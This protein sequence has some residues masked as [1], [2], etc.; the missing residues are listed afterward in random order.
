MVRLCAAITI[1]VMGLMTAGVSPRAYA[2]GGVC[3]TGSSFE[4]GDGNMT[5]SGSCSEDWSNAPNITTSAT[6]YP[7]GST[8]N[9]FTGGAKEDDLNPAVGL[10]SVPPNKN[11]LIHFYTSNETVNG[12][13]YL[14][15]AFTRAATSGNADL[16]VE[17]NHASSAVTP[18]GTCQASGATASNGLCTPLQRTDGDALL[19]F[20]FPGGGGPITS[21]QVWRWATSTSSPNFKIVK[22]VTTAA[23][24]LVST[25][26]PPCWSNPTTPS[27]SQFNGDSNAAAIPNPLDPTCSGNCLGIATFGEAGVNLSGTGIFSG[28]GCSH[29]GDAWAKSRSSDSG[30]SALQDY[31]APVQTFISNCGTIN[32]VKQTSPRGVNQP[33]SFNTNVPSTAT[34]SIAPNASGNFN[35]ND[36]G[37]STSNSAA[38]TE[39]ITDI[40]PGQTYTVQEN[41]PEPSGFVYNGFSCTGSGTANPASSTTAQ[42][43]SITVNASNVETCTFTNKQVL[44]PGISTTLQ[45]GSTVS[46]GTQVNDTATLTGATSTAGGTVTYSYY[47]DSACT[48]NQQTAGTVTVNNGSVPPSNKVTFNSAG[49][50]YFQASYSGDAHNGAATSPCTSEQLVVQ[51]N[52]PSIGTTLNATSISVGS[53]D[54]DTSTLTGAT[55]NAGGTVTYTVY[56]DSGCSQNPVAG[57]TVTV[58]SGKVPNSNTLT[59]NTAGTYYWQASYSG[60]ANNNSA[61]SPCTSEIV[62]VNPLSPTISTSLN[63]TSISVGGTDYDTATLTGATSNAGGT[64]TYTV[65]SDTGCS[66]NPVDGGTVTVAGGKVPNSNTLSFNTAGTYYWQASYSGDGNNSSAVSPCTS[67]VVT[68]SPLNPTISTALHATSIPVGGTDYDTAT[69]SGATSDASG[70]VTYTVFSD[71]ACKLNPTAAGTATVSN[72]IVN[73]SNTLTFSAV[74]TYYWQASYSGDA[75][76][77]STLS[78]CTEEQ[79]T[80]GKLSPTIST[81]LNATSIPVG[82]TDYDTSTLTGAT[83]GA[84]GTVTYTVFSDSGCSNNP[85]DG[86]TVT[87][88]GGQ[89]PQ[90]ST[91]TFNTAGTYYWQASYS[92]DASNN[93]ASS[94]CTS[95][96]VTVN[97]L[98]PTIGTLLSSSSISVGSTAHDTSTLSGATSDAG[99][100]VTYTVYT[101]SGCSKNPVD[102]G[103]VTVAGGKVP[104]SSTLTFNTAGTY[105]WQ[106]VYSGDTNNNG[107]TSTCTDEQLT[108]T[109]LNP[110][111][112]TGQSITPEDAA[113]LSGA[114]ASA[115]GTITFALFSPGDSTCANTPSFTQT[116]NVSGNGSYT[117]TNASQTTPFVAST[118]GTWRWVVVYSGDT[119]NSG[120]TETCGTE[121]FTIKNS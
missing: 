99:G 62:T 120:F 9:S 38:N 50:W 72:G 42:G 43:T 110:T 45:P 18:Q 83:S 30:S 105:Y 103:T 10:Q 80:V 13:T 21:L 92:G 55:S 74:G 119:N 68:V 64:V 107:A 22:G 121:A 4:S 100:T 47:T 58:A 114:T 34:F 7:S 117:T 88:T 53:T 89:V 82:S 32:V 17:V 94:A 63:S 8:D 40:P 51:P 77:N 61:T 14:Y 116:V 69:L 78:V 101:D 37:N 102:G 49:T 39:T 85:V 106:A 113:T 109:K 48:K 97:K 59:F 57:G 35:L 91:L 56:S 75:N 96:I 111:I 6:D 60:D 76:N 81:T 5:P 3:L 86:G 46:I 27:A 33:F 15:L 115:G 24:C 66:K 87:V 28:S 93:G 112:S 29:F 90:S 41:T 31:I 79:L 1:A 2:A 23:G 12:Q 65:Y 84:S 95:E 54:F 52:S 26:G 44:S 70:T 19:Q 104:N 36:N 25:S 98:S 108:V 11:D 20:I 71:S 73:N 16:D 118:A 67:E